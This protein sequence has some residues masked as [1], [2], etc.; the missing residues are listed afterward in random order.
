VSGWAGL[1]LRVDLP[2][3]RMGEFDNMQDRPIRATSEWAK[4]EVVLDA[5]PDAQDLAFGVLIDGK[6]AVW[7]DDVALE[8]VD[9]SVAKTG[10]GRHY[11]AGPVN[12]DFEGASS[13]TPKNT[14]SKER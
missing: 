7:I 5:A 9:A 14:G 13:A 6:G 11:G 4:Y 8:V 2:E 12:L 10:I 3:Q 1:W